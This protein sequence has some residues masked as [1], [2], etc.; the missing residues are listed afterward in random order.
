MPDKILESP[1]G[2]AP[3]DITRAYIEATLETPKLLSDINDVLCDI[4]GYLQV[5]ALCAKRYS[6]DKSLLT[7]EDLKEIDDETEPGEIGAN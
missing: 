6:E 3:T 2:P 5:I 7:P 4:A 1:K